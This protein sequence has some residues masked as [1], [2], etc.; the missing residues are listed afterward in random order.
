MNIDTFPTIFYA[1]MVFLFLFAL[2][3][4][5]LSSVKRL[6]GKLNWT[7]LQRALKA[8]LRRR[9]A[10]SEIRAYEHQQGQRLRE[11]FEGLSTAFFIVYRQNALYS[12]PDLRWCEASAREGEVRSG[13][14][15]KASQ[16]REI[17][18]RAFV[19]RE[20]LGREVVHSKQG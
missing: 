14:E 13:I 1:G 15:Q 17:A 4:N 12:G 20:N 18:T 11:F 6:E 16:Y 7:A 10:M 9:W 8:S 3:V 5:T 19:A 2:V